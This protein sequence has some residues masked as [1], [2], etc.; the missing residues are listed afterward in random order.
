MVKC[1]A[2]MKASNLDYMFIFIGTIL[3]EVGGIA[4]GLDVGIA[5]GS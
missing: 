1:L 4:F 3:G 2:L 5:L